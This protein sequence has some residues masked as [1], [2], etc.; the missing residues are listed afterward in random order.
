[1]DCSPPGSSVYGVLQA[2]IL[3]WVAVPFSRSSQPKIEPRSSTLQVDS[4]PSEP[5]GMPKNTGVGSL[6]LLQQIFPTQELNQGLLHCRW[7]FYQLSYKEA[8]NSIQF[9]HY[10]LV[11]VWIPADP[12][13]SLTGLSLPNFRHQPQRGVQANML[14]LANG[15]LEI[16]IAPHVARMTQSSGKC[17]TLYHIIFFIFI[18]KAESENSQVKEMHRTD[19]WG[20]GL[21]NME[22]LCP[23][24]SPTSQS[25]CVHQMLTKPHALEIAVELSLKKHICWSLAVGDSTLSLPRGP[26]SSWYPGI[27]IGTPSQQSSDDC[28][29]GIYHARDP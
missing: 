18:I 25:L 9:W 26:R 28:T 1:M 10:Q 19:I 15:N 12:G 13:F 4:L 16:P 27:W 22:I 29:E 20:R 23:F 8:N 24:K 17:C 14:C 6:S 2:R 5:P 7:I 11:L 21:A 3:G